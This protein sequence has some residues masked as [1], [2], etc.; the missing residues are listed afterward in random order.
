MKTL[1][2]GN[3]TTLGFHRYN[4]AEKLRSKKKKKKE[5]R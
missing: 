5:I 4:L 1:K 2:L 3:E